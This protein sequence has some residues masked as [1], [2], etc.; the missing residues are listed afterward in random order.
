MLTTPELLGNRDGFAN[1]LVE[2]A[3]ADPSVVVLCADLSDSMRLTE[4]KNLFPDRYVECGVAEQ[5]MMGVASGLALAGKKPWVVSYA[6]FNPER[7]LDQLRTAVYS[8]L[9]IKVVGGHSGLAT[10][11]YGSTHQALEDLAIMASLPKVVCAVP[12]DYAQ[13]LE[14][15]KQLSQISGPAYLRL[16]R[17][18]L[19]EI[20]S[21]IPKDLRARK[22]RLKLGKAEILLE[23]KDLSIFATGLMVQP[24]IRVALAIQ[25]V[26]L[27]A[28]LINLHTIKP[29]D[30]EAILSSLAKTGAGIVIQE[31]QLNFGLN[32]LLSQLVVQASG[33]EL[34]HP[35]ALE[36]MGVDD[37]FGESGS[38]EELYRK[39]G[40]DEAGIMKKIKL[41][42][43]KKKKLKT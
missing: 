42:L 8:N 28:E 37:G 40:L 5:N 7:N 36:L 32:G 10:G 9:N 39:H 11:R 29:L 4:F 6:V 15:T 30:A 35:I 41:V 27:S 3:K 16:S 23:G 24:A 31:H 21:L 13:S 1:A 2:I 18:A 20:S 12:A 33:R 19:P 25:K 17:L 43:E 34:L 26:G 22:S 38:E 14:L